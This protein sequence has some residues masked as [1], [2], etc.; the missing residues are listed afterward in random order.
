MGEQ[1]VSTQT[2]EQELRLFTKAVLNDLHA[3]EKM[4]SDGMLEKEALRIGAE[5]EMFLVDSAMHPKS[6][7]MQILEGSKR[8][9]PDDRNRTIQH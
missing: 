9:P 8:T 7:A 2:N 1:K 3:L 4:I 5:Q 6:A